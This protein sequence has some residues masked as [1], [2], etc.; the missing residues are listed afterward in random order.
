MAKIPPLP[1]C[2]TC[3]DTVSLP[4][5]AVRLSGLIQCRRTKGTTPADGANWWENA[6]PIFKYRSSNY[7]Y[8]HGGRKDLYDA[9]GNCR[10]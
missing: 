8:P 2:P 4:K 6:C 10:G 7:F 9:K 1:I 3:G 5:E